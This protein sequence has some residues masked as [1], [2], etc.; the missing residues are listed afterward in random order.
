MYHHL[1]RVLKS[2][3][4]IHCPVHDPRT[5][6]RVLK[7]KPEGLIVDLLQ[8]ANET[9]FV[10]L[11]EATAQLAREKSIQATVQYLLFVHGG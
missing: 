2:T 10:S 11:H 5:H 9:V 7:A 1:W 8:T 3:T 4:I 6:M